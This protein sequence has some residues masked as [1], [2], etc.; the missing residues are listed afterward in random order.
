MAQDLLILRFL[1]CKREGSTT[2]THRGWDAPC[3][4]ISVLFTGKLPGCPQSHQRKLIR[5]IF[6]TDA[7]EPT[8]VQRGTFFDSVA[9]W[10]KIRSRW[11]WSADIVLLPLHDVMLKNSCEPKRSLRL[12]AREIEV[13][14]SFL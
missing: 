10:G 11:G 4:E 1:K 8:G 13:V 12:L 9:Y 7:E 5:S 3:D 2:N 14:T 6:T